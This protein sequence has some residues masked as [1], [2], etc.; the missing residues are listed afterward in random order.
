M[1]KDTHPKYQKVLFIDTATGEKRLIG[2]TMHPK[3]K[4]EFEG[5]EYPS[6]HTAVS[7]YSH[8][9]YTGQSKLAD[10][11]GRVQRFTKRYENKQADLKQQVEEKKAAA[12]PKKSAKKKK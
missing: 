6:Y 1:K 9:F 10:T 2:T 8:P 12:A 3:T 7:S 4:D 5:K 11:E